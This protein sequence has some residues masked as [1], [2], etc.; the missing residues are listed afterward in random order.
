[1]TSTRLSE[2]GAASKWFPGARTASNTDF[3]ELN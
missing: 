3:L 1:M 2:A